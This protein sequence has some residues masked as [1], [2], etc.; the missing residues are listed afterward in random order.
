MKNK[1]CSKA[2][3]SAI[4]LS[5]LSF[6]SLRAANIQ[7]TGGTSTSWNTAANWTT[8]GSGT[9]VVPGSGDDVEITSTTNQ[10]KLDVTTTINSLTLDDNT[11]FTGQ[12]GYT[13]TI[14]GNLSLTS[15]TNS[16]NFTLGGGTVVVG[17]NLSATGG[18]SMEVDIS[19]DNDVLEV[20]GNL[21][22]FN[23]NQGTPGVTLSKVILNGTSNQNIDY[24]TF[25]KLEIDNTAGVSMV[26][27]GMEVDQDLT[28]SGKLIG[29]TNDIY[30]TG[31]NMTITTF[32]ED[33][34]TFHF[35]RSFSIYGETGAQN[36]NSY[37]FYN[38]DHNNNETD[39]AGDV[40][41]SNNIDFVTG[42]VVCGTHNFTISSGATIT[43]AGIAKGYVV[44][45]GSGVLVMEA[46]TSGITYPIG[47]STTEYNPI[48]LTPASNTIC[49]VSVKDH[50]Y[51]KTGTQVTDYAVDATW[52]VRPHANATFSIR[53]EWTNGGSG[54]ALVDF[55][56]NAM[57]PNQELGTHFDRTSAYLSY[58]TTGY[59]GSGSW[60]PIGAATSASGS[61]PYDL[62]ATTTLAMSGA[63]ATTY[64]IATG[65]DGTSSFSPLPVTF[66]YFK[67]AYTNGNGELNWQTASEI[68]NSRFEVERSMNGLNWETV[69][70]V[71]GHGTTQEVN[72]YGFTDNLAG[73]PAGVV[74]YRLKQVD[75]N[76]TFSYSQIRSIKM[77]ANA[78][79]SILVYP[80]PSTDLVNVNYTCS[81]ANS[82]IRITDMNG[83]EVYGEKISETGNIHRQI[84]VVAY[85][86]G[87]YFIQVIAN[88]NTNT[89]LLIKK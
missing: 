76:G 58:R 74:Y 77:S 6:A 55:N 13:L 54:G 80:N 18:G 68:N 12:N 65:T 60:S 49:D 21:S 56:G 45:N 20:A 78:A 8:V 73:V 61:D 25:N 86:A 16:T 39:L 48:F 81:E 32:Q 2:L 1:F 53:T 52:I 42:D 17:G 84:S 82:I 30:F 66:T 71:Q 24:F 88:N 51:D 41:V 46:P 14:S 44:T 75:Y 72:N 83:M 11:T 67:A 43:N 36:I 33:Q 3:Y 4:A 38:I 87:T 85:P 29:G 35:W 89:N 64:Y 34:S 10:P 50:L 57:D 19:N 9:H 79:V 63:G 31:S 28:G 23:I 26:G 70:Q 37:T 59:T 69:G 62:T 47:N 15:S 40:T 27:G 5:A 22:G 7:W